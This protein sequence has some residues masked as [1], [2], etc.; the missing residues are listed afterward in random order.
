MAGIVTCDKVGQA[1]AVWLDGATPAQKAILEE[2]LDQFDS[3]VR[4]GS[5]ITVGEDTILRLVV[6]DGDGSESRNVDITLPPPQTLDSLQFQRAATGATE[7]PANTKM[8][9]SDFSLADFSR[10]GGDAAAVANAIAAAPPLR[11]THVPAG[12][13]WLVDDVP[14]NPN[15]ARLVGGGKVLVGDAYGGREQYNTYRGTRQ[16]AIGK[17][18][19]APVL[20]VLDKT[21]RPI[22]LYA[23]GDST[24]EGGFNFIDWPFFLQQ[25]LPDMAARTFRNFLDVTNRGVG[26]SNLS[27]WNPGPDIG[28]NSAEPAD[29]VI[30]KCG[31]ND[32]TEGTLA[33]RL[34]LFR[35]RLRAGLQA[36]RN[37]T[38]GNPGATAILLVGPNATIDKELH[39]RTAEWMEQIRPIMEA[40]ARDFH[41]AYFDTYAF[42]QDTGA[43][44]DSNWAAEQWLQADQVGAEDPI[45]LHPVNVGQAMIWGAIFDFI[46]NRTDMIRWAGNS[47]IQKS[48]YFGHPEA[49]SAWVPNNYDAGVTIEVATTTGGYPMN[50]IL[51]TIKSTEGQLEQRLFDQLSTST[52]LYRTGNSASGSFGPWRGQVVS[53]GALA[54]DWTNFDPIYGT[55][56]VTSDTNGRVTIDALIRPGTTALNTVLF[57]LPIGYRPGQQ[58]LLFAH[59]GNGD[60]VQLNVLANGDVQIA[61]GVPAIF[62]ALTGLTFIQ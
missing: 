50:G 7:R 55:P 14:A 27:T 33:T 4:S 25:I 17:E 54:N 24:V 61:Q 2:L 39:R 62:L 20:K 15:G 21:N 10:A 8:A 42:M 56:R 57:T 51:V 34:G 30:L 18:F 44:D 59:D 32:G 52:V 3:A 12:A 49:N 28:S 29:L 26:G 5:V 9:E 31:I 48:T 23:Y 11:D 43:L 58:R 41:C 16:I 22:R 46:F 45:S 47:I 35:D 37:T 60:P 13:E 19:F 53:I 36:I 6:A 1:L 40:A 38:G